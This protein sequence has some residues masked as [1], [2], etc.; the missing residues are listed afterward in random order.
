MASARDM[1][2]DEQGRVDVKSLGRAALGDW[3]ESLGIGRHRT[4][5]LVQSLWHDGAR[6]F[7]EM[8]RFTPELRRKMAAAGF[9]SWLEPALVLQSQ[10]GTRKILWKLRDGRTIES[11]VIPDGERTTLC[12]SS[13]VGCAMACTF[14]LTG[15]LGLVRHLLPSEI[16]N[17]ALQVALLLRGDRRLTNVVFMGMGEPLH[18]LDHLCTALEHYQ[19]DFGLNLS[20]R[21]ITVSTVGL[22]PQLVE[23]ARRSPVNLAISLNASSEAERLKIMPI[24]KKY[25]VDQLLDACRSIALPSGKRIAFEYVLFEGDNDAPE[26]AE[27]LIELLRGI[28]AKVNLIPYNENPDRDIHRPDQDRV[29]AFQNH[30]IQRGLACTVRTTRGRDISAACGQ[31]GKAWEQAQDRGWLAAARAAVHG[32]AADT[33]GPTEPS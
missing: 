18:N 17:Q 28:P 14:C 12:V 8:R 15:D 2:H 22:V 5:D 24:T 26:D 6:T 21:R 4:N 13:Q 19:D 9:V 29:K 33:T 10:D 3:L 1:L 25:G 20:H 16:A 31:L 23:F 32:E 11:V 7:E 27:R 30:L